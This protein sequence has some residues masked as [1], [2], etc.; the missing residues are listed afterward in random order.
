MIARLLVIVPF[1]ATAFVQQAPP[2]AAPAQI[3]G[4]AVVAGTVLTDTSGSDP[5]RKTRVSLNSVD[6]PVP[7]QTVATDDDGRFEFRNVPAGRY[8]IDA[9]KAGYLRGSYGAARPDRIGTPVSVADG[10]R[11]AGLTIRLVHGAAISGTVRDARGRPMHTITVTA[12]RYNYSVIGE[13]Q[14]GSQSSATTDDQGTYRLWGLSPGEYVIAATP[15]VPG[16]YSLFPSND[17][18]LLT[19][20]DVDRALQGNAVPAANLPASVPSGTYSPVFAPGTP[21]LSQATTL[22]IAAADER[23]GVDVVVGLVRTARIDGSVR[24]PDG[25]PP[26]A[27]RI[28]LMRAGDS[29]NLLRSNLVWRERVAT[30]DPQG[31]FT[32]S[33]VTPGKYTL[34]AQSTA[35]AGQTAGAAQPAATWAMSEVSVDGAD[36]AVSLT[37]QPAM[38]IAGR[39]VFEGATAP[40]DFTTLSVRL[41]PPGSGSSIGSGPPGGNVGA[42]RAFTFT[43]VMP[44]DYRV[45]TTQRASW[46]GSWG[47]RSAMAN[48][49][50]ALDGFL[51][52]RPGDTTELVLTYTD[53]PTEVAGQFQDAGGRPAPDYFIVLFPADRAQ[54]TPGSRRIVSTRPGNDG[55]Y[56]LRYVPPGE[57]LLAALTDLD[58]QDLF[59][60]SFFEQLVPVAVNVTLSEGQVAR[61]DLSIKK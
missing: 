21:D 10:S 19:A 3:V 40:P 56:S 23:E 47:L 31:R 42:D 30:V 20:A 51:T 5:A 60:A 15:A 26:G 22:A 53:R 29:G 32:I 57:Y 48:N 49:R 4:T 1:V 38:T 17:F 8:R 14:L 6:G 25:Q 46:A 9:Q 55:H 61:R 45:L 34:L 41:V 24:S 52:I 59:S 43:R 36:V 16:S 18:S 7:G 58:P 39:V 13:R 44:G 28:T 50:D 11:T 27:V 33:D 37:M 2:R 35:A 54:W 12:L